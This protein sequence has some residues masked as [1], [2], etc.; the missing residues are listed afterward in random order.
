M[1][2]TGN[3]SEEQ[4]QFAELAKKATERLADPAYEVRVVSVDARANELDFGA[5]VV[6]V[7][8]PAYPA[9]PPVYH[10]LALAFTGKDPVSRYTKS[11][12]TDAWMKGSDGLEIPR[13]Q[14]DACDAKFARVV[15]QNVTRSVT[16]NVPP[17]STETTMVPRSYPVTDAD[18]VEALMAHLSPTTP[19]DEES[20]P[21]T[22]W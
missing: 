8:A 12:T 4:R 7:T 13:F 2:A 3:R 15:A 9:L 6:V 21:W 11:S 18:R 1:Q 14:T 20:Q 5:L 16:G 19:P 10:T 22:S 17:R